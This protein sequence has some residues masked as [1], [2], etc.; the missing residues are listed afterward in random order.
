MSSEKIS[1]VSPY[2][3][4]REVHCY[5]ILTDRCWPSMVR[6]SSISLISIFSSYQQN[7]L[8]LL[9][10]SCC[11]HPTLLLVVLVLVIWYFQCQ[12]QVWEVVS[13]DDVLFVFRRFRR[14]SFRWRKDSQAPS[15][16]KRSGYRVNCILL[17]WALGK[18]HP[19]LT[20]TRG[21]QVV[22]WHRGCGDRSQQ[23]WSNKFFKFFWTCCNCFMNEKE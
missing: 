14:L 9:I 23:S 7:F 13:C 15:V 6:N 18:S 1:E 11:L 19:H 3:L 10:H 5:H 4:T 12:C 16:H 8:I 21:L 17:F 2:H 20:L 22:P